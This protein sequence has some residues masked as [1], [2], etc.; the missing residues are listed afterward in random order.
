[1]ELII[2][3]LTKNEVIYMARAAERIK[4]YNEEVLCPR[5]GKLLVLEEEGNSYTIA[6]SDE[7]CISTDFRGI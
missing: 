2:K 6:C 7:T 3:K 5:C 4:W 1:M